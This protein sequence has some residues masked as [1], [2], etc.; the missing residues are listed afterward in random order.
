MIEKDENYFN[1]ANK[2]LEDNTRKIH[3]LDDLPNLNA[4]TT[5]E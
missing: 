5:T 2:R 3:L 4:K 1:I